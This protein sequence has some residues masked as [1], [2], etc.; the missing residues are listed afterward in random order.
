MLHEVVTQADIVKAIAAAFPKEASFVPLLVLVVLGIVAVYDAVTGRVPR[1][2]ITIFF[3]WS[4]G[5]LA[6]YAGWKI[7]LI[8]LG[9]ATAIS[10]GLWLGNELYVK[11]ADRD[12]FGFGDVRWSALATITYGT[13]HVFVSWVVG[14]WLALFWLAIRWITR[15]IGQDGEFDMTIHFVPFLFI[16]L[17]VSLLY[18][19]Y[20]I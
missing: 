15:R 11:F 3:L 14:A 4:V 12:A 17:L 13:Q 6:W 16:G 10:L 20:F 7:A 9:L 18:E 1:R 2:I 5:V 8:R 19:A